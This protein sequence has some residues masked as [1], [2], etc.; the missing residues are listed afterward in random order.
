MSI[1]K[2]ILTGL[3]WA[4]SGP[5]GALIGYLIGS[6]I[7]GIASPS[8]PSAQH[9]RGRYQN[10]GSEADVHASLLVLIAAVMQAD[11]S[12]QRSELD[13]VK[14]FL[15]ENYSEDKAKELLTT[16]RDLTKQSIPV[17]DVCMQI[18]VNT[19]YDTRYHI[20]DFLYGLA[21]SDSDFDVSEDL[22]L[23]RIALHLGINNMD[24]RSIHARHVGGGTYGNYG[25]YGSQYGGYGGYSGSRSYNP[26]S[27]GR[28][29]Y[30]VLGLEKGASQAEIKR[31]YR[32]LAMKYHPDKVEGMGE[33]VKKNS[34]R[35]FKEINEAYEKLR[36]K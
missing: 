36:E 10:R 11:G 14:R 4:G 31:A 13:Y 35:Q 22:I 17:D 25:G 21:V 2:W 8:N 29:P 28:D 33:E 15:R 12:V 20:V 32:R 5:I 9:K 23:R 34:E 24:L 7:E 18:K 3:G 1:L 26:D 6:A 27:S 16:L 30:E 19:S